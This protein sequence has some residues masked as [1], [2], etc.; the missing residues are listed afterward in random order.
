MSDLYELH[1]RATMMLLELFICLSKA[2]L[3]RSW[4]ASATEEEESSRGAGGNEPPKEAGLLAP[5]GAPYIG[6]P[7]DK[8]CP[9]IHCTGTLL[10]S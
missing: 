8:E 10:L 2:A 6:S 9:T 1:M 7:G 3:G 4:R 5:P